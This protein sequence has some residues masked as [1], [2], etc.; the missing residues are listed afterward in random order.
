MRKKLAALAAVGKT[1][2]AFLVMPKGVAAVLQLGG[3]A[4]ISIGGF[5]YDATWGFLLLGFGLVVFGVAV[6]RG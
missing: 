2:A 5:T 4:A 6:E 1:S 3:I